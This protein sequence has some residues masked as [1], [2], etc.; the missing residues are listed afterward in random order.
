LNDFADYNFLPELYHYLKEEEIKKPTQVQAK[1]IADFMKGDSLSVLAQ[2]GTG[3][4]LS[5]ALPLFHHIKETDDDIPMESQVG[6]PRAIILTP[7]RE[8]NQQVFKVFKGVA[9]HA[10]LRIRQLVG[11]DQGKRSRAISDQAYDILIASPGRL[12]SALQRKEVDPKLLETLILDEADQLLD[13]GFTKDLIEINKALEVYEPQICLY[14]ATWPAQYQEFV[15]QVFKREDFKEVICQGGV[16]LSRNIETFNLYLGVKEKNKM[17][18]AFIEKEAVGSGVVF[19]NKKEDVLKL[20]EVVKEDFPRKRLYCLHGDMTQVERKKAYQDFTTKGGLLISSDIAARGLD[21]KDLKWILN[22][23]LPFEAVYYVHRCGRVG[24]AGRTGK[25]YNFVTP[26]DSKL[27][28]RINEAIL[29]QSSLALKTI[30]PH[31]NAPKDK[32]DKKVTKKA[33]TL[34]SKKVHK[35]KSAAGKNTP[36]YKKVN[37]KANAKRKRRV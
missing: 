8:L 21:V 4:T 18:Q 32:D 37:K 20:Y 34:T 24:R 3:K 17:I 29:G 7:T 22:F 25:V 35:K 15:E 27:M 13:M 14:S 5:Y 12:K 9:H 16:Q 23:D 19:V 1:T 6:S 2:T 26:I 10:K 30:A 33:A 36:R 28:T 11:G 31:K